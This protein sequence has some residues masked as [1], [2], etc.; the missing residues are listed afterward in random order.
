MAFANVERQNRLRDKRDAA[1]LADALEP[2]LEALFLEGHTHVA[3]AS[4][5]T[6]AKLTC[7]LERLLVAFGIVPHSKRAK[8]PEAYLRNRQRV[9]DRVFREKFKARCDELRRARQLSIASIPDSKTNS[10]VEAV[11]AARNQSRKFNW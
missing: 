5:G 10:V 6:V 1:A 3:A 7:Q 11:S 2:L 8:D 4:P 9:E